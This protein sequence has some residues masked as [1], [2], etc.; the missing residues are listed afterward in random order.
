MIGRITA[1]I[2]I[3]ATLTFA[4]KKA[5]GIVHIYRYKLNQGKA[6]HPMVSC[7]TFALAKI[8]NGRVY[9]LK[10]SA[11]RHEFTVGDSPNGINVDV[12]PGK[13]YY[14]RID[15]NP[16]APFATGGFPV[17]VSADQGS[18]EVQKLKPLD[19]WYA[20]AATCGA[21]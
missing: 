2:L 4:Q 17:L 20:E 7:D 11:E 10:V 14:V 3:I 9:T 8:Q 13:E 18:K 6:V 16:N 1:G 12:Q 19:P 21:Q 5:P 15:F